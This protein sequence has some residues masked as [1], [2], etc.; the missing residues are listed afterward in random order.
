M[1]K[2]NKRS[3]QRFSALLA[4]IVLMTALAFGAAA[5]GSSEEKSG[6]GSGTAASADGQAPA[7]SQ[8]SND[9]A[10]ADGAKDRPQATH[11]AKAWAPYLGEDA[12]LAPLIVL[13]WEKDDDGVYGIHHR[14]VV[15]LE[16]LVANAGVPVVITFYDQL[17]DHAHMTIANMEQMAETYRGKACLIMVQPE[18][19]D[20]FLSHFDVTV[21]PTIYY[22]KNSQILGHQ[23]GWDKAILDT[24]RTFC[25]TGKFVTG[26]E[27]KERAS[28]EA[29]QE[30]TETVQ[31]STAP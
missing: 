22:V 12:Y 15:D 16:G 8:A 6:G 2:R 17:A 14:E 1:K 26:K 9:E 18:A 30:K 28:T 20:P 7:E 11:G 27:S 23:R 24:M 29:D 5:C 10:P 21:L 31:E 13:T 19:K 3:A 25:E 4:V